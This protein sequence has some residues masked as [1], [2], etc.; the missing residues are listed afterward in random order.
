M[1]RRVTG[2]VIGLAGVRRPSASSSSA[3]AASSTISKNNISEASRPILI[4]FDVNHH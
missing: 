4:K 1:S 2:E 3:A